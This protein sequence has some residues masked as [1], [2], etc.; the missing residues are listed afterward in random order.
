MGRWVIALV[1]VAAALAAPPSLAQVVL[2]QSVFHA[3]ALPS[4]A[5]RSFTVSCP[6]GF[7]A[8]SAGVP[9]PAPGVTL[10]GIR[11]VGFRAYA[12]RFG[13]PGTNPRRQVTA[14]VACRKFVFKPPVRLKVVPVQLKTKVRIGKPNAATFLCPRG[15]APAGWGA[16]IAPGRSGQGYVPGGAARLSLRRVSMHLC[17]FS[18]SLRNSGTKPR[19]VTLYGT[20]LTALRSIRASTERLHVNIT[21]FPTPLRHGSQSVV[22]SC[23]SGW[24]SLAAGYALSSPL[25]RVDGATVMRS[26]GRWWLT[27]EAEGQAIAHVQLVCARLNN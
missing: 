16:E 20:C 4:N 3:A 24:V 9:N 23:P 27:S 7:V 17:G 10:L 14:L 21:T 6:S 8:A 19:S 12:F 25:T 22:E 15:T 11:P 2:A 13:N 1:V 26:G 5:I 18:F